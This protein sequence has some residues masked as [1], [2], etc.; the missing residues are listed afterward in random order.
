MLTVAISFYFGL[1]FLSIVNTNTQTGNLTQADTWISFTEWTSVADQSW[2]EASAVEC[3]ARGNKELLCLDWTSMSDCDRAGWVSGSAGGL[4]GHQLEWHTIRLLALWCNFGSAN[5][6]SLNTSICKM[7]M[8]SVLHLSISQ[9]CAAGTDFT[10]AK[11]LL[12]K[13]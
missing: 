3:S 7:H 6:V 2:W 11:L 8:K 5:A 1:I 10:D 4:I 12:K 13:I 9:S